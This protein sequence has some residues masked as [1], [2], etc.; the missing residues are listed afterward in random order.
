MKRLAQAL[1]EKVK[2]VSGMHQK[3][4]YACEPDDRG[5]RKLSAVS[6]SALVEKVKVM[7]GE[8]FRDAYFRSLGIDKKKM[9]P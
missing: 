6:S 9:A 7:E 8:P 5:C 4:K 3:T 2:H 1:M